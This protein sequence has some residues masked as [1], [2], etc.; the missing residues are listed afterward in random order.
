MSTSNQ[1]IIELLNDISKRLDI[2]EKNTL[3]QNEQSD[4]EKK[5]DEMPD[6]ENLEQSG[7]L[8]I[9]KGMSSWIQSKSGY[10]KTTLA[11]DLLK[12]AYHQYDEIYC[13][14][15][16]LSM[17]SYVSMTKVKNV[18]QMD[19]VG[20]LKLLIEKQKK[21]LENNPTNQQNTNILFV[22]DDLE[23]D[24]FVEFMKLLENAK[25]YKVDLIVTS[26]LDLSHHQHQFFDCIFNPM[27]SMFINSPIQYNSHQ[28]KNV[29]LFGGK[30]L[31]KC[32]VKFNRYIQTCLVQD[33]EW[34]C[35]FNKKYNENLHYYVPVK[36]SSNDFFPQRRIMLT[37]P[38]PIIE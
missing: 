1:S 6:M 25:T 35:I 28:H 3:N 24:L 21:F 4:Q 20:V 22:I 18:R 2:I 15:S 11:L 31:L 26:L 13:T 8:K 38:R 34:M 7:H 16:L 5:H 17:E 12:K 19:V 32:S 30:D 36:R 23:I 27:Q 10:G 33:H 14:E 37:F 9:S 29:C